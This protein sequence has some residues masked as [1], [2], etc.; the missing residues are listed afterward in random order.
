MKQMKQN[1]WNKS[2]TD[3]GHLCYN[4]NNGMMAAH[5]FKPGIKNSKQLFT[6]YRL[7]NPWVLLKSGV[8]KDKHI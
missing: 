5:L 7:S 8:L 4:L 2:V 3:T 6:A 1:E